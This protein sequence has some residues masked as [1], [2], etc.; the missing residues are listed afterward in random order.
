ML[1]PATIRINDSMTTF[2]V[3][4]RYRTVAIHTH[5][6]LSFVSIIHRLFHTN[7][8]IY[9]N[10]FKSA[11]SFKIILNNFML[12]P[13]LH[14]IRHMLKAASSTP[15]IYLTKRF[16]TL[17][18]FGY[19]FFY[20]SYGIISCNFNYLCNDSFAFYCTLHK[21]CNAFHFSNSHCFVRHACYIN[22]KYIILLH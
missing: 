21:N 4:S 10:P 20:S 14:I 13:K 8:G 11:Y 17:K 9:M 6:I 12:K 1:Y 22:F 18:T 19:P 7:N 5:G 3:K 15:F 2:C 16:T